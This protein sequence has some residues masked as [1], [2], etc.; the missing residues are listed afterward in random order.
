MCNNKI[1][2]PIFHQP[3]VLTSVCA[4]AHNQD[5]VVYELWVA[6]GCVV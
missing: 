3:V 5:S 1:N 4:V 2:V 6:V